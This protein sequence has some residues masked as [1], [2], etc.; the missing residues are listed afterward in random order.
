[1][2]DMMLR[3]S[4]CEIYAP[5]GLLGGFGF[6]V[7]ARWQRD[8]TPEALLIGT[9]VGIV[10]RVMA[11]NHF[12]TLPIFKPEL[13]A[14]SVPVS[15]RIPVSAYSVTFQVPL[16]NLQFDAPYLGTRGN[17]KLSRSNSEQ[18][19]NARTPKQPISPRN[20]QSR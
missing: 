15:V 11:Y 5:C 7:F 19:L 13:N 18:L 9:W 2:I 17:M 8:M 1:M 12:I 20:P 10:V 4:T 14:T 6:A 16:H 3:Y